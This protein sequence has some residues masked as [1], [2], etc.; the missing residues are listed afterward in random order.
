MKI[1]IKLLFLN[2]KIL[3]NNSL[4]K[5][6]VKNYYG[7]WTDLYG[8]IK[9]CEIKY[10]VVRTLIRKN[11]YIKVLINYYIYRYIYI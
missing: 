8:K 1:I 11:I 6:I 5:E 9:L 3:S 4:V 2:W 7:K 10:S